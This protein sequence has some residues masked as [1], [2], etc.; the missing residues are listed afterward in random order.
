MELERREVEE[1]A[2]DADHPCAKP[3]S[4]RG[5]GDRCRE[6]DDHG[7]LKVVDAY[8]P[9]RVAERLELRDLLTLEPDDPG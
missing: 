5:A 6:D 1:L 9:R 4:Q 3:E 7:E 8:P 2:V